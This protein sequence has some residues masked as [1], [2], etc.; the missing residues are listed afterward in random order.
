MKE[1]TYLNIFL[2]PNELSFDIKKIIMNKLKEK[3]LFKEI[4]HRMITDIE[5]NILQNTPLSKWLIN[6]IE[7][8][9]PVKIEYKSYKKGDIIHGELYLNDNYSND[10]VFV[11]S[12]D[13]ICEILNTDIL[14]K[15]ESKN[16]IC[17]CL[18]NIKNTNG[19]FYFLA[20]GNI[21]QNLP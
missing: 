20:Q 16:H 18:E 9:I 6:T 4:E 17:V 5:L 10:R 12:Y 14:N 21:I 11:M 19:C 3:Y 13:V 1:E 7:L 2:Y 15:I 8:I